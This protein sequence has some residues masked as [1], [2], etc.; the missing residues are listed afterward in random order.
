M[1]KILDNN[2]KKIDYVAKTKSIKKGNKFNDKSNLYDLGKEIAF[3]VSGYFEENKFGFTKEDFMRG[4]ESGF[5]SVE[6]NEE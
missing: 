6:G 3:V 1:E 4:L 2:L 5:L